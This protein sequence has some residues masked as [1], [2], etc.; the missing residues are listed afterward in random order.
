MSDPQ[1]ELKRW[2]H[3]K[4]APHGVKARL[5]EATG[6]TPTQ[7]SRMRNFETD[8]PK[9]RQE[10]PL[11]MIAQAARFFGELPPGFE[12]MTQWLD[13]VEPPPRGNEIIPVMGYI[14]A[15]AEVEPEAE[16]VPPDGL[17]QVEIPFPLPDDMVAFKVDGI[18]MLPVYRPG[19]ILVVYRH[20]KKPIES[21]FGIEAAVRTGN[22]RR[23]IKTITRGTH[24]NTVNLMS[25]NADMIENVR[26]EWIGEIFAVLPP[27]AVRR[28]A[29][30]GGIQGQLRIREAKPPQLKAANFDLISAEHFETLVRDILN[31]EFDHYLE[32]PGAFSK[33]VDA[34][35]LKRRPSE[36]ALINTKRTSGKIGREAVIQSLE[37]AAQEIGRAH[38]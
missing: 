14:G 8:D 36:K 25:F 6:F 28:V 22:G 20:Q 4:T 9:K 27:A 32:N 12:G 2:F 10:I 37:A 13:G 11:D 23:Y 26:L 33:H 31:S 16:Q 29:R 38:V 21:F 18:S 30:Q 34:I 5:A 35:G 19:T 24:P 3:A 1:I 7:I 15:G 17:D